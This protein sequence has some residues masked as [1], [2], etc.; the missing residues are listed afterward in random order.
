[1]K[2]LDYPVG[3]EATDKQHTKDESSRIQEDQE[4]KS[5]E[6][7][8]IT[9]IFGYLFGNQ[10]ENL[11]RQVDESF[12]W[13]SRN[14]QNVPKVQS[15]QSD[16]QDRFE[17]DN[18]EEGLSDYEKELLTDI[19]PAEFREYLRNSSLMQLQCIEAI[20]NKHANAGHPVAQWKKE[21]WSEYNDEKLK[22]L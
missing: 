9:G 10:M 16:T 3:Q 20:L 17:K 5:K 13:L 1:M 11:S 21:L 8:N 4:S 15:K 22:Q 2:N 18:S 14:S 7:K 6:S 12:S 19:D